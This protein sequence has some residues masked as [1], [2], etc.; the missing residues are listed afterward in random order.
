LLSDVIKHSAAQYSSDAWLKQS[1]QTN[2]DK[3]TEVD[4]SAETKYKFV[5]ESSRK[6]LPEPAKEKDTEGNKDKSKQQPKESKPIENGRQL[7]QSVCARHL[8]RPDGEPLEHGKSDHPH[9][10]N[11]SYTLSNSINLMPW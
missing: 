11:S 4:N 6:K 2:K 7:L 10:C 5:F 3:D 9:I 1:P 8:I